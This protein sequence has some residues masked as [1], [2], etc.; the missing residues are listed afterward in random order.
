MKN[1]FSKKPEKVGNLLQ[2]ETNISKKSLE[3]FV[4]RNNYYQLLMFMLDENTEITMPLGPR[5]IDTFHSTDRC[6]KATVT[7]RG[8]LLSRSSGV[9]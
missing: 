7:V 1:C 5:V 9:R 2:V 8:M 3:S 4:Y 6:S